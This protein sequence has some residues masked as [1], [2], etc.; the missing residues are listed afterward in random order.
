MLLYIWAKVLKKIR[1]AAIKNSTIDKTSKVESG[2]QIVNSTFGRHSFCGYDCQI[3][4]CDVG[5]FTSIANNVVI[6]GAQ[7]PMDWVSMSPVFYEGKDSVKT[8]FSEHIRPDAL[9]TKVGNDVWIG[10]GALIKAGVSVGD[11]AVVG[12]GSVVTKNVAP[13][14]IV[15]GNPARLIKKRFDEDIID[16]LFQLK[17]WNLRDAEIIKYAYLFNN[18]EEFKKVFFK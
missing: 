8:K 1:G 7:H 3:I 11:G 16:N 4:N 10:Q 15:A 17:W 18:I 13:Y 5:S 2:S 9:K 14:C 6:G 12:M